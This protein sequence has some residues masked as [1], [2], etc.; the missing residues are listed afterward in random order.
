MQGTSATFEKSA[1]LDINL[2]TPLEVK[3]LERKTVRTVSCSDLHIR[4]YEIL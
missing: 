1:K 2:N 4:L 3:M